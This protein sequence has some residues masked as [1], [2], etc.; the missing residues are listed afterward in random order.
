MMDTKEMD[1][2]PPL[3]ENQPPHSWDGNKQIQMVLDDECLPEVIEN[4]EEMEAT[5]HTQPQLQPHTTNME[6]QCA[7]EEE[8]KAF[9]SVIDNYFKDALH[10][11]W[12]TVATRF[13][14]KTP[15]QLQDCFLKLMTNVNAIKNGYPENMIIMIAVPAT[16]LEYS[17]LSIPI[18]NAT[19]PPPPPH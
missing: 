3:D 15:A 6:E 8:N 11:H 12:E 5:K 13:P 10:N 19:P 14:G 18:V 17:P 7:I 2:L 16:P 4:R 1:D 9:E